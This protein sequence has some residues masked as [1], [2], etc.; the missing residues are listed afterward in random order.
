QPAQ[1]RQIG[2]EQSQLV[3]DGHGVNRPALDESRIAEVAV[4]RMNAGY[5]L[6]NRELEMMAGNSFV[7]GESF[8]AQSF[9]GRRRVAEVDVKHAGPAPIF[10]GRMASVEQLLP[11][12]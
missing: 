8:H 7:E 2:R 5:F 12:R 4:E 11:S 9:A 3:G 1:S 6:G 10:G